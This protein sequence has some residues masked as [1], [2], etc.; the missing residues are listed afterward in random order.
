MTTRPERIKVKVTKSDGW[1]IK[2]DVHEVGNYVV[3]GFCG[4]GPHFEKGKGTYGIALENCEV[5]TENKITLRLNDEYE[6]EV[7]GDTIKVGCAEFS[8]EKI[9]ELIEKIDE[10]KSKT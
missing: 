5:L 8:I 3:F 7:F 2:G 6:A 10:S 1:S 4:G 9:R